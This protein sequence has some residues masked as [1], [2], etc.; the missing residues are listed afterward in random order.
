MHIGQHGNQG[1]DTD[2]SG[3][4]LSFKANKIVFTDP[5]GTAAPVL[6]V[7]FGG[8]RLANLADPGLAQDAA[9]KKYVD[10]LAR[11]GTFTPVLNI[12]SAQVSGAGLY[13]RIGNCVN[14]LMRF[15]TTSV[16]DEGAA[17]ISGMPFRFDGGVYSFEGQGGQS[18]INA[19]TDSQ[20]LGRTWGNGGTVNNILYAW[21]VTP[22]STT[23]SQAKSAASIEPVSNAAVVIRGVYFTNDT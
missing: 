2:I 21:G 11:R 16:I 8:S 18:D 1:V 15:G 3:R 19:T 17:T 7:D 5:D 20:K 22:Q 4:I 9:T 6:G 10:D 14:F 13:V 12:G 23:F